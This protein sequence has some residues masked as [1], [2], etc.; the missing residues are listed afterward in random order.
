MQLKNNSENAHEDFEYII[1]YDK[2][3]NE[4]IKWKGELDECDAEIL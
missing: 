2:I 4:I 1:L 3:M